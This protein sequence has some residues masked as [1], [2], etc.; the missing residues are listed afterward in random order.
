MVYLL[1]VLLFLVVLLIVLIGWLS[2]IQRF[3]LSRMLGLRLSFLSQDL[4]L[5]IALELRL[6][7]G[8]DLREFVGAIRV[9]RFLQRGSICM[10]R[11]VGG[12][13]A[14]CQVLVCIVAGRYAVSILDQVLVGHDKIV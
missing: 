2:P 14:T 9:R 1:F 11:P 5:G 13:N 7:L 4:R 12:S 6:K 3:V 10:T 8:L